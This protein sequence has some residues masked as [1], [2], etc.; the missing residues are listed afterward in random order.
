MKIFYAIFFIFSTQIAVGQ[1]EALFDVKKFRQNDQHF[2]ETYL[3]I[4]GNSLRNNIDTFNLDKSV[5]VL[6]YI[7]NEK[8]EIVDF[9]KYNISGNAESINRNGILDQQRFS[10]VDGE[11][12]I[13]LK[14][15]DIND[16]TNKEEHL[17]KISLTKATKTMFSDIEL[18]DS[19][20]KSD[21]STKLNK[22][23]IE[24]IPLVTTYL[25]PEFNKLAYYSEI[26]FDE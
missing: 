24:M 13:N 16:T 8:N 22:S 23:G 9:K 4:Y 14:L 19:Y 7:E 11:Y 17:Q 21:S 15:K 1:I 6:Q 18:L 20:W 12:T 2:I 3:Y 25:G 10:L 26:Y 5:E